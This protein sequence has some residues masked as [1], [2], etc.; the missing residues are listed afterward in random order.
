MIIADK[1]GH[2]KPSNYCCQ[3]RVTGL[4]SL[5][6]DYPFQIIP[7]EL[8]FNGIKREDPSPFLL[9]FKRFFLMLVQEIVMANAERQQV[10]TDTL[11]VCLFV[12]LFIHSKFI[13]SGQIPC[14]KSQ[15]SYP[16]PLEVGNWSVLSN[17]ACG[18][19][20]YWIFLADNFISG[21]MFLFGNM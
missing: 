8:S 2:R 20:K 10:L 7:I 6:Q 15:G 11:S 21:N 19:D 12:Y 5:G 1:K 9:S 14:K 13:G 3:Q 18:Q 16:L 4:T 17:Q